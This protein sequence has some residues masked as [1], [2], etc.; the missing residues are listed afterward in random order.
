MC[1]AVM[2]QFIKTLQSLNLFSRKSTI[3]LPTI[4]VEKQLLVEQ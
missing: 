4:V 2:K 1:I 3:Q